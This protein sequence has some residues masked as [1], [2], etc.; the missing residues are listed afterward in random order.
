[1]LLLLTGSS[2]SAASEACFRGLGAAF[3][4]PTKCSIMPLDKPCVPQGGK[5]A[6]MPIRTLLLCKVAG[7]QPML[8]G[9][10]N[11]LSRHG[12]RNTIICCSSAKPP[13]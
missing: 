9:Q 4:T 1:M 5:G 12:S 13:S 8:A 6:N 10:G 3:R 7:F 11:A 2:N